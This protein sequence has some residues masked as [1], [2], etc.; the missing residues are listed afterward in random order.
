MKI[1]RTICLIGLF[2]SA[3]FVF[4]GN[5]S[6]LKK[7]NKHYQNFAFADAIK[8]YEELAEVGIVTPEI[9]RKLANAY[10]LTGKLD[11]AEIWYGK[12]IKLQ[13]RTSSEV[14]HYGKI[15]QT[16]NELELALV[17]FK[18]FGELRPEDC[19]G[20]QWLKADS[21]LGLI[22]A[23]Q[24][25]F[26][27]KGVN[28]NTEF[29]EFGATYYYYSD[30]VVFASN[31]DFYVGVQHKDAWN[32]EGFFDLFSMTLKQLDSS[33]VEL[34]HLPRAINTKYHESSGSF[35]EEGDVFY[36]TRNSFY[37][38]KA[39]KSFEDEL[40]KL[41]VFVAEKDKYGKWE[42]VFPFP[43]NNP[44]YSIGHPC[45]SPNGKRLYF[46]SDMPGG[47]G[48]SDIW[49]CERNV[50]G[51]WDKPVNC[52][53]K[54][55]TEGKEIS[56][57]IS[58]KDGLFFSSDGHVGLG[59]FDI[60][61]TEMDSNLN[62]VETKNLGASINSL[63]DDFSFVLHRNAR[64][65]FFSSNRSGG[66]GG[67]D[68]YSF[69]MLKT[70]RLI[71]TIEGVIADKKTEK[72]LMGVKLEIRDSL[73]NF[74]EEV[75]TDKNGKY[76]FEVK[77]NKT[78]QIQATLNGLF[79]ERKIINTNDLNKDNSSFL[80]DF[81]METGEDYLVRN[82]VT[83]KE[84]KKPVPGV[85]VIIT[86]EETGEI[87]LRGMTEAD[88]L[89]T[90]TIYN[91]R[92]SDTL[93]Y[94]VELKRKGYL[95]KR[96]EFIFALN[97]SIKVIELNKYINTGITRPKVGGD[98][99]TMI[100]V[101]PILFD[102][103]KYYIRKDAAKELNKIADA[104][105]EYPTMLVELGA[106]TDCRGSTEANSKLS[107]LRA[108]S[109]AKYLIKKGIKNNRIYGKGYGEK[110]PKNRCKCE[111]WMKVECTEKMHQQNR[112]SEFIIKDF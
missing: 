102:Y 52:G 83:D 12:L 20:E 106:H 31:R 6:K 74:I 39:Q 81:V 76:N 56:P 21:I 59:G 97:D 24:N 45:I 18:L 60:F 89:L 101:N 84:T 107:H 70:F 9:T 29:N 5:P 44:E 110:K 67:D 61:R 112:R 64:R 96:M 32:N 8:L 53:A 86:D 94:K 78:Y 34:E 40:L 22:N 57:F 36:F 104:M 103:G 42:D 73:G 111:G 91:K 4:A 51:K 65:G 10:R 98:I 2:L 66:K 79:T 7:A 72:T 88:G 80:S 100:D 1:A 85:Q 28:F 68:I 43:H 49:Y 75:S 26:S 71:Y 108:E 63:S 95:N 41:Q 55:N 16:N 105:K 38:N 77:P 35:I 25:R 47:F 90:A 14:Y 69:E 11:E 48:K 109:S 46:V 54:I 27:V 19:R 87:V 23:E 17:Q 3:T 99:A 50:H 58:E 37:K 82:T 93:N 92:P 13:S 33:E 62:F 15:L 30:K